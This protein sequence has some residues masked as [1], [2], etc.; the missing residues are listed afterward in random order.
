MISYDD[1]AFYDIE[2]VYK[3]KVINYIDKKI[4]EKFEE[5]SCKLSIST[6][7]D[8]Y[9]NMIW[10]CHNNLETIHVY[11]LTKEKLK[12][13]REEV[14]DSYKDRGFLIVSSGLGDEVLIY[15]N[16]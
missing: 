1:F 2:K 14:I 12:V 15:I 3:D 5:G 10:N 13:L 9:F 6:E 8:S 11:T 4:I 7:E 16:L